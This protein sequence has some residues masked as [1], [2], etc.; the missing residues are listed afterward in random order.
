MVEGLEGGSLAPKPAPH[1]VVGEVL[2]ME[3]LHGDLVARHPIA[4]HEHGAE[5]P[6]RKLG[7]QLVA[8]GQH[9]PEADGPELRHLREHHT[10]L[11]PNLLDWRTLR[12]A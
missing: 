3:H 6:E 11:F 4:C 1:G 5:T 7:G 2:G 8:I 9:V 10:S 12:C